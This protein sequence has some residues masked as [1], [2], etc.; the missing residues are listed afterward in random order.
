MIKVSL[1]E[2]IKAVLEPSD[3]EPG[4]AVD[5]DVWFEFVTEEDD[6]VRPSHAALHGTVWRTDDPDAPV[7]PLDFRCRCSVVFCA[8]PDSNAAKVLPE[9][10]EELTT[11]AEAFTVYLDK[12][13][14]A[15]E[16]YV[17]KVKGAHR[18][19]FVN[20]LALVIQKAEGWSL[21]K[22]RDFATIVARI[23]GLA[24]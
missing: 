7:P 15:W 10:Q 13:L 5:S 17:E 4:S 19:D 20:D 23:N 1:S 11:P 2:S 6:A 16:K 3:T 24:S 9:T 21:T 18:E 14:P 12:E 22:S 8:P